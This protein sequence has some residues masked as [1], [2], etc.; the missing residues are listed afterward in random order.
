MDERRE[1]LSGKASDERSLDSHLPVS[2]CIAAIGSDGRSHSSLD[3]RVLSSTNSELAR[4]GLGTGI[5][6][7]AAA[8]GRYS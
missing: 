4:A 6:I 3:L 8:A 2:T 1:V 5:R 7:I